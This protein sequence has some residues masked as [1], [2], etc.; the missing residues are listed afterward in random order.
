MPADAH[1]VTE[2]LTYLSHVHAGAGGDTGFT[3]D[4]FKRYI[5]RRPPYP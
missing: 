4:D 3:L 2:Y 5:T 1:P